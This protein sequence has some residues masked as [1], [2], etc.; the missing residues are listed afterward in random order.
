MTNCRCACLKPTSVVRRRETASL[1]LPL[2][3]PQPVVGLRSVAD[4]FASGATRRAL[5]T[6]RPFRRSH[7]ATDEGNSVEPLRR[8]CVVSCKSETERE[9]DPSS[10]RKRPDKPTWTPWSWI[11]RLAA[12]LRLEQLVLLLFNIQILFFLLRLWPLSGRLGNNGAQTVNL[13]VPFSEFV[14]R[15]KSN[16]VDG[17]QMDGY[18]MTFTVRPTSK[19]MKDLPKGSENVKLMY[20]TVRPTDY[21]TPYDTLEQHG[22]KFS[23]LE[24]RGS[25]IVTVMVRQAVR[26]GTAPW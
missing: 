24:K 15:V 5:L 4:S 16:E 6:P 11:G 9:G 18:D 26:V 12:H 20:R 7:E 25:L 17:V 1:L 2:R 3:R 8:R 13:T 22:V 23:S 21:P 14:S 10:Q 19:L